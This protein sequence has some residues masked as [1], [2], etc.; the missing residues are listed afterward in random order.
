MY[1][2]SSVPCTR[3]YHRELYRILPRFERRKFAEETVNWVKQW[4][5]FVTSFVHHGDGSIPLWSVQS[6]QFLTLASDPQLTSQLT[7]S[8]YQEDARVF[9]HLKSYGRFVNSGVA[10]G[11]YLDDEHFTGSTPPRSTSVGHMQ[12]TQDALSRSQR[13]QS[14]VNNIDEMRNKRLEVRII[15]E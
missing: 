12:S 5:T 3:R 2:R 13:I 14:C 1:I 7:D 15:S 8:L 4:Y 10:N 6:F 11:E 9:R